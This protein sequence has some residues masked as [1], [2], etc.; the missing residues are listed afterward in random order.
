MSKTKK[1]Y[2]VET[3]DG[4][5]TVRMLTKGTDGRAHSAVVQLPCVKQVEGPDGKA[6]LKK[7]TRKEIVARAIKEMA[8]YYK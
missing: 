3:A 4:R 7:M 2:V 5:L 6:V 8:I 1:N